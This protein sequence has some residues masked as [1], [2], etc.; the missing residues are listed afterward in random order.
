MKSSCTESSTVKSAGHYPKINPNREI[1]DPGHHVWVYLLIMPNWLYVISFF[2]LHAN[3]NHLGKD[4]PRLS[5]L[6]N[7]LIC[8][9]IFFVCFFAELAVAGGHSD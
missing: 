1:Q 6:S 5:V 3:S 8:I 9:N 7:F 4:C 2:N